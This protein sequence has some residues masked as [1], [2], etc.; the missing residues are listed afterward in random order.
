M[1]WVLFFDG[2]CAFCS[3]SVQRV[4]HFDTLEE[5]SFAP[6]QGKLSH[7]K[8]FAGYA[9]DEGGTMLLFR[10][11]DGKVFTHSDALIQLTRIF[12]GWWRVLS[13]AHLI[14]KLLRDAVYRWIARNRYRIMERNTT[15]LIPDP[16]MK[17]RLRD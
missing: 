11:S 15:C 6:L 3:R 4:A 2:D 14:P 16:A 9:S 10:E 13:W 12:G 8:G 5:I 7:E 17:K 1:N